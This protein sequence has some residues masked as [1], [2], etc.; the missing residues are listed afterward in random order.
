MKD[1]IVKTGHKKAYYNLRRF[2]KFSLFFALFA[3]AFAT[4]VLVTYSVNAEPAVAENRT[5]EEPPEEES[6]L[7]LSAL[8]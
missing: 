1:K 3:A 4:P 7:S 5:S 2:G 8:Y 6:S